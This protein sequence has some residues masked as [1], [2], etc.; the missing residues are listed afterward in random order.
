MEPI[1]PRSLDPI[2]VDPSNQ[3]LREGPSLI[4]MNIKRWKE[5]TILRSRTILTVA[6][7]VLGFI[8]GHF[9]GL[10]DIDLGTYVEAADGL[11]VGELLTLLGAL[12]AAYFRKNLKTD[13]TTPGTGGAAQG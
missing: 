13:L 7:T 9:L 5:T 2:P 6:I 1:Q 4:D 3:R 10:T 12:I 8:V 11:Q